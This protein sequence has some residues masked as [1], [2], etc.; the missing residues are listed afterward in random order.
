MRTAHRRDG[1]FYFA[2]VAGVTGY[3]LSLSA[4]SPAFWDRLS[5][6]NILAMLRAQYENMDK[7][8]LYRVYTADTLMYICESITQSFGGRCM[9]NRYSDFTDLKPE[10][11]ES[12]KEIIERIGAKLDRLGGED[13][14]GA[15]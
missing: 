3:C 10:K 6:K 12:G 14:G 15:T 2:A 7:Q 13:N 4:V 1:F 5:F 9:A 8:E 11:H